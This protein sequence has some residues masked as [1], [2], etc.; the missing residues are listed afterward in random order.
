MRVQHLCV[1]GKEAINGMDMVC[2]GSILDGWTHHTSE[3]SSCIQGTVTVQPSTHRVDLLSAKSSW[4]SLESNYYYSTACHQS[5]T[6]RRRWCNSYLLRCRGK[7]ANETMDTLW[8][9]D[10]MHLHSKLIR[11]CH[12]RTDRTNEQVDYRMIEQKKQINQT[13]KSLWNLCIT[14][15]CVKWAQNGKLSS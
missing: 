11:D 6:S 8:W 3:Y 4:W 13:N 7:E 12:C 1:I 5:V 10:A 2:D 14:K 15:Y 9:F